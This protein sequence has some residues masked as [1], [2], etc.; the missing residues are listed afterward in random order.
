MKGKV[1]EDKGKTEH[2]CLCTVS[3][4]LTSCNSVKHCPPGSEVLDEVQVKAT[5][6]YTRNVTYNLIFYGKTGT[7][8]NKIEI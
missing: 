4:I 5:L 7:L 8:Q 6:Y 2:V 1:Q 3:F